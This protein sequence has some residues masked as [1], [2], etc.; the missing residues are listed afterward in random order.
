MKKILVLIFA[1][2]FAIGCTSKESPDNPVLA[3]GNGVKIT[4]KDF[5]K[6]L[7]RLPEWARDRYNTEEGRKDLLNDLVKEEL[8]YKEAKRQGLNRD[9]E[10]QEALMEFKKGTLITMLIKKELEEKIKVDAKEVRDYY[11]KQMGVEVRARH[12]LVNTKAEA[13]DILKRLQKGERFAELAKELSKDTGSAINGG[14]LGFFGRGKMVPEFEKTAFSLKVGEISNPVKTPFGY[15][16]IQITD[17]KDADLRDFEEVK[18]AIERRLLMNKQRNY[19]KSY[20]ENLLAK[21]KIE[22]HEEKLTALTTEEQEN[23]EGL[24]LKP[25]GQLKTN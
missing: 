1:V 10:Y 9:P 14:D 7:N 6:R 5:I 15:H 13:D 18:D 21:N 22:I 25:H 3:E 12:I 17:K 23:P 20:A 8:L 24:K 19:L 16:I 4:K 2:L 11:E